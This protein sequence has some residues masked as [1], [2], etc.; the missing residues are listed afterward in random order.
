MKDKIGIIGLGRLGSSIYNALLENDFD[1]I[2][3]YTRND[4][5]EIEA[6]V[7][8][9]DFIFLCTGDDD[10]EKA[11]D[12]IC[13]STESLENKTFVHFSG[14]KPSSI[15]SGLKKK[16]AATASFHP[17]QTFPDKRSQKNLYHISFALEGDD[18]EEEMSRIFKAFD[19]RI[20]RIE[21]FQKALYHAAAVF[22][23]NLLCSLLNIS[24]RLLK[25]LNI[26]EGISAHEQL[27]ETTVK[28]ILSRGTMM[29]LTGPAIRGDIDSIEAHLETLTGRDKEIY[30]LLTLEALDIGK[31]RYPADKEKYEICAA[32][33]NI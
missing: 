21:A 22:S 20:F 3:A 7:N 8:D 28:N 5:R 13:K 25:E 15:L 31:A 9:Y 24:D 27:I 30:K 33:C 17:L 10:I 12:M 4:K 19:P 11:A 1:F 2:G 32:K 26:K 23:S 6:F 29:S 14:S 18:L 16:G